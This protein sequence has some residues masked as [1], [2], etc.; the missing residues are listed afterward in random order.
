MKPYNTKRGLLHSPLNPPPL[1]QERLCGSEK[2]VS[3]FAC[4]LNAFYAMHHALKFCAAP[5]QSKQCLKCSSPVSYLP[6]HIS[7]ETVSTESH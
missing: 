6:P 2:V 5:G 3:S 1:N 7:P 4:F